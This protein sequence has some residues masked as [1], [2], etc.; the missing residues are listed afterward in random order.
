MPIPDLPLNF[1][2]HCSWGIHKKLLTV[3]TLDSIKL[4]VTGHDALL[5]LAPGL[6]SST[7]SRSGHSLI[8]SLQLGHKFISLPVI[9]PPLINTIRDTYQ[10]KHYCIVKTKQEKYTKRKD[11]V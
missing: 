10:A 1:G 5:E 8:I 2:Q 7:G 11:N 6:G 4:G 9:K 3:P